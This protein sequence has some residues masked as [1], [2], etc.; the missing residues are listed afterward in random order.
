MYCMCSAQGSQASAKPDPMKRHDASQQ[1]A[2]V[3][4]IANLNTVCLLIQRRPEAHGAALTG[5]AWTRQCVRGA[6]DGVRCSSRVL[7]RWAA[8]RALP[9]EIGHL[10]NSP[11]PAA[12]EVQDRQGCTQLACCSKGL[13]LRQACSSFHRRAG[14]VF[15]RFCCYIASTQVTCLPPLHMRLLSGVEAASYGARCAAAE[16]PL[17]P[18]TVLK[19][20]I[21]YVALGEGVV[22]DH[23][24]GGCCLLCS[25][26]LTLCASWHCRSFLVLDASA[27]CLQLAGAVSFEM[28]C[29]VS[30]VCRWD[31][32]D[33][34][35]LREAE[36]E[37][38]TRGAGDTSLD[39]LPAYSKGCC[40]GSSEL[41]DCCQH[42]Q[43]A[44]RGAVSAS[45]SSSA[46]LLSVLS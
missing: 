35:R 38:S 26:S 16:K 12:A 31:Q 28:S 19:F 6:A 2:R 10:A 7:R 18:T 36:P 1:S 45:C 13:P 34:K 24:R 23:D 27:A 15:T 20:C 30:T 11:L 46:S 44:A 41:Q 5:E 3:E 43:M 42:E 25:S 14:T 40:V 22:T 29:A 39:I 9:D 32:R 4:G 37:L 21:F 33:A 17:M 8:A